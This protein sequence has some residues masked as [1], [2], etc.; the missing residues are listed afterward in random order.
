M[1]HTFPLLNYVYVMASH[2]HPIS[3]ALCL[4]LSSPFL[5]HA[6]APSRHKERRGFPLSRSAKPIWANCVSMTINDFSVFL[7]LEFGFFFGREEAIYIIT[8]K[9][10]CVRVKS[11]FANQNI[12]RISIPT[13][14][15]SDKSTTSSIP[16]PS[17]LSFSF[18][19]H[20]FS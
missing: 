8:K 1:K 13:G 2:S 5:C 10:V 20:T 12:F 17:F 11:M 19:L 4:F 6:S 14:R 7:K 16:F 15:A 3:L 18:S 9:R